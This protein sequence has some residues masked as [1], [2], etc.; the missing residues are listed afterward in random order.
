MADLSDTSGK[1]L[2]PDNEE[3]DLDI[4]MDD[5]AIGGS[6]KP[7]ASEAKNSKIGGNSVSN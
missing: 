3:A 6:T 2:E 5:V 1:P 4:N 7:A